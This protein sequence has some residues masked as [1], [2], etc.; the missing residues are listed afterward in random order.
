MTTAAAAAVV[1]TSE[2]KK[3][4]YDKN[5]ITY[6]SSGSSGQGLADASFDPG[7]GLFFLHDRWNL[8]IPYAFECD[9]YKY[10]LYTAGVWCA[11]H[12]IHTI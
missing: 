11:T 8:E 6:M 9:Y 5:C 12:F 2:T 4:S 10:I 7:H 1:G 3:K